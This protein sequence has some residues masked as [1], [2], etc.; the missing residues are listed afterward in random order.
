MTGVAPEWSRHE[1]DAFA[2]GRAAGL[3]GTTPRTRCPY[4][5]RRGMNPQAVLTRK[6]RRA[7]LR[8]WEEGFKRWVA[9]QEEARAM[10]AAIDE[11]KRGTQ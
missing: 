8:G 1:A 9:Q 5:D 7:W 6:L 11:R 4:R 2:C 3:D 10:C